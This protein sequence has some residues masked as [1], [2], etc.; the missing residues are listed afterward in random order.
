MSVPTLPYHRAPSVNYTQGPKPKC[1]RCEDTGEP[2]QSEGTPALSVER[3][4]SQDSFDWNEAQNVS[5]ILQ[6]RECPPM[7]WGNPVSPD[8]DYLWGPN[9]QL[10]RSANLDVTAIKSE[11]A[12]LQDQNSPSW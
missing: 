12:E 2:S 7:K 5:R 6:S 4:E 10:Q 9:Q 11:P 8:E 1:R 3:N